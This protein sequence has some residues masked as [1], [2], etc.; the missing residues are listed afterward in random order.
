MIGKQVKLK[1][2]IPTY[3]EM[4]ARLNMDKEIS[5]KTKMRPN[6][7]LAT[8]RNNFE[9][10]KNTMKEIQKSMRGTKNLL[11]GVCNYPTT[12][13]LDDFKYIIFKKFLK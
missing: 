12:N 11:S 1:E 9:S 2:R 7:S 13:Y 6:T 8:R 5:N 3:E 4:R 10:N